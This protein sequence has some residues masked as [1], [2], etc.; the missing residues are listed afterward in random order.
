MTEKWRKVYTDDGKCYILPPY[1]SPL[2]TNAY[3]IGNL[4]EMNPYCHKQAY[5][6]IRACNNHDALLKACKA[7]IA[8]LEYAEHHY[9]PSSSAAAEMWAFVNGYEGSPD[10]RAITETEKGD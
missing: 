9:L 6:V 7:A 1:C 5:F 2:D 4:D 10:I 3:F 8:A